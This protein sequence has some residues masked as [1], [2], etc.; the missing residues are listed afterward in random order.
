[1]LYG[2]AIFADFLSPY[3]YKNEERSYSYCPPTQVKFFDENRLTWPYVFGTRM[4]FGKYNKRIYVTNEAQKYPV[5]LFVKG[6]AYKLLGLFPS[7]THLFGVDSPGRIYLAGADS[8][9]G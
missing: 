7:K 1:V 3:S 5:R 6:D 9:G 2:G 8:R 4:I